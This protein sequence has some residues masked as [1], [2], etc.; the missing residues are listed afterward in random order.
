[1]DVRESLL[2]AAVKVF[3][4]A[5]SRGATTRRIAQE[6]GVN[7]VT[8]FRHFPSKD[9]LFRDALQWFAEQSRMKTLPAEPVDPETELTEW[10]RDHH[11]QL[12]KIRSLIRKSMGEYEEFPDRCASAMQ[13]SVRISD[14]LTDYL[15]SLQDKGLASRGWDPRAAAAMLMG[16]IFSDA[17]GRDTMPARYP[18][19]MRDAVDKYLQI[20]FNAI[21]LTRI[22]ALIVLAFS[23]ALAS[24]AHA[25]TP[26]RLTLDQAIAMA[27]DH[28]EALAIARAGE[29]RADADQVRV[30]SQR[31]PQL[32]F[33][34]SYDRTLASEFS[35]VLDS[36]SSGSTCSALSVDATK[37]LADR[38]GELERAAQCGAI[39][40]SFNFGNL[41]FGQRN[42][43]RLTFSFSQSVYS[44]GRIPAQRTQAETA[45]RAAEINTTSTNAQLQLE[46]ARAFFDAAL[47]DRMLGIAKAGADQSAA[48]YEQ[49]QQAFAAG[50]QPEFELLRAQ[51]ARDNQR[52][53][54]IRA[55]AARDVAYLR[56]RQLLELPADTPLTL[57]VDLDAPTLATPPAFADA[58][59]H[60]RDASASPSTRTVVE[61]ASTAVQAREAGV[62][63]ARAERMPNVNLTSSYGQVG[64]PGNA[65]TPTFSDFRT[66]WTLG[67]VVTVPIL[68]GNRLRADEAAARADLAEAEARLKQT[69][70]FAELDSATALQDLTAA[71]AV[72]EA[73][74]G[75]IQQAERAYDIASLRYREGLSTQLELSDS[76]LAL[77]IAQ[78]N[79]AQAARDLQV[80][81]VR[82]ALL[83]AL[84]ISGRN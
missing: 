23:L 75:T 14:E 4:E 51:V 39:G 70:E 82:V 19:S 44:G 29:T 74:G 54:V 63:V 18:Y 40:P 38:V 61:Q 3:A 22:V 24:P 66:N 2:K 46:V 32:N 37:P 59:T 50:R 5:G 31:L 76:R 78:A 43:Y 81:R 12:Y 30:N 67:A 34:G 27:A 64:Y 45:R 71:E 11:K 84:P 13:V 9:D 56:L 16:T 57:D 53:N 49:T 42:V 60:A 17:L 52:P 68:T 69:K 65:F 25:Q 20:F 72:W 8:L 58:L 62:S 21:G 10:S 55:Q 15:A 6:A 83:P 80:A 35:S 33:T 36:T 28:S 77:Q 7:E 47:S 1:M 26:M 79:R 41:P 48:I 73:T